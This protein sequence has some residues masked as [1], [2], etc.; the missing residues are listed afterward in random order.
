LKEQ[1]DAVQ[2]KFGTENLST[3]QEKTHKN[4]RVS[5]SG[6]YNALRETIQKI[7]VICKYLSI[8]FFF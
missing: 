1:N 4:R 3:V 5:F 6:E 7:N 2:E 8:F